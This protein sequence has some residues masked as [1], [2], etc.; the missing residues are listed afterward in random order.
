M[1]ILKVKTKNLK[2]HIMLV[3]TVYPELV[4]GNIKWRHWV[5]IYIYIGQSFVVIT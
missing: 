5:F 3:N 1:K 4:L 2:I